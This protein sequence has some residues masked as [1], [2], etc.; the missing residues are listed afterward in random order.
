M[1]RFLWT[2]KMLM[3]VPSWLDPA[4]M[5]MMV[6]KRHAMASEVNQMRFWSEPLS[7]L[8]KLSMLMRV[9]MLSRWSTWR[10]WYPLNSESSF[11]SAANNNYVN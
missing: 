8:L 5:A 2:V 7:W 1:V 4:Q 10:N 11:N 9:L 3:L 6:T